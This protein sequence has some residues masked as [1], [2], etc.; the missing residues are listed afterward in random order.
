[1]TERK[2]MSDDGMQWYHGVLSLGVSA[3]LAA[4]SVFATPLWA[5]VSMVLSIFFAVMGGLA[6]GGYGGAE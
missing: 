1:M 2:T 3:A 4:A 5:V 6:I